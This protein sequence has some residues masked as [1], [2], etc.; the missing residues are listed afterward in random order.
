MAAYYVCISI[1]KSCVYTSEQYL[2]QD[3]GN[4]NLEK[5]ITTLGNNLPAADLDS[6]NSAHD[7]FDKFEKVLCSVVNKFVPL[8]KASRRK[9][10][11]S[12]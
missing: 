12:V 7:A 5:F 11:S 9:K 10:S 4:F 3:K 2:I 8:K 1:K 6:I